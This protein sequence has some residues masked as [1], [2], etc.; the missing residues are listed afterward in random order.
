MAVSGF[1]GYSLAIRLRT[2]IL[3]YA[4]IGKSKREDHLATST[5]MEVAALNGS[6]ELEWALGSDDFTTAHPKLIGQKALPY[7]ALEYSTHTTMTI[8]HVG[9][10]VEFVNE[11]CATRQ[12]CQTV[13]QI[14]K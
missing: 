3:D 14:F 13:I 5:K 2:G 6:T 10:L 9:C 11:R 7:G 1:R 4:V 8:H 12:A